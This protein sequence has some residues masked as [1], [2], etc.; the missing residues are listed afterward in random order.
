MHYFRF[1]F[2]PLSWY[3]S[4][5]GINDISENTETDLNELPLSFYQDREAINDHSF[6]INEHEIFIPPC[7]NVLDEIEGNSREYC[8]AIYDNYSNIE[9]VDF[10]SSQ[11]N[12]HDKIQ[13]TFEN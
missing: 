6:A 7:F 5:L 10:Y 13:I 1:T 3:F 4:P 8:K 2:F 11:E 12:P 9:V